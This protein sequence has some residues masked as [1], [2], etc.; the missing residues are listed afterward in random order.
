MKLIQGLPNRKIACTVR[1][2]VIKGGMSRAG[3]S[4]K[5]RNHPLNKYMEAIRKYANSSV[6]SLRK[7]R[8]KDI[9]R[10][11][12]AKIAG[13]ITDIEKI[14]DRHGK[15]MV[16]IKM[17][18]LGGKIK[19]VIFADSYKKYNIYIRKGFPLLVYGVADLLH[20]PVMIAKE[21]FPLPLLEF[22]PLAILRKAKI[23]I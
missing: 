16:I 22:I 6:T 15:R 7:M 23:N 10:C 17:R 18:G 11:N 20:E 1:E 13:V 2:C 9:D 3:T 8:S 4:Q 5:D 14:K 12:N 21:I 19:V